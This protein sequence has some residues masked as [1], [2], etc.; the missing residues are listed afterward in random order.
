[1]VDEKPH[2]YEP[3]D[4]LPIPTY[5]EATSSRPSSAQ[6]NTGS[7]G[8]SNDAERQ[9]LLRQSPH[10]GGS[11][12]DTRFGGYEPPTVESARTSLEFL[13]ASS[14]RSS[15]A[16]EEGL[17][18]EITQLTLED[19]A[20]A[21]GRSHL[22]HSLSKRITSFTNRLSSIQLTIRLPF[23]RWA[24]S[25]A[26]LRDRIPRPSLRAK[27][28]WVV[29]GRIFGGFLLMSFVYVLLASNIFTMSQRGTMGQNYDP[30]QVRIFVQSH[31]NGTSIEEYLKR[32]TAYDH[33]AGTEGNYVLARWV[34]RLF[35]VAEIEDVALERFDVY[36]NYPKAGG[37]RVAIVEPPE[38]A[39]EA[40]MEEEVAY[41]DPPRQQSLVFHG[42]SQA[43]NVTGPLVYANYGSR[44]DF[45][46]L[47]D[48][49]IS[50]KGAIALVRYYGTQGDRALKV[51]A[52]ELAGAVG[53]IIYSDPAEDGFAKGE[54]WPNGRFMPA[55]GVQRGTVGLTSWIVGDVL[56]PGFASLPGEHKRIP[57]DDNPGLNNIPSIPLAWRDA[58]RLLQ[59][60]KGHGEKAPNEW[61]GAVP[62]VDW[63]T[64]DQTSPVVQLMNEQD[65]VEKQPIYNVIGKISGLE[66]GDGCCETRFATSANI[67]T[68]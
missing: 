13:S 45:K 54:P 31:V 65:E 30:E 66:V 40:M 37:R 43:G 4:T 64:G 68:T 56:S 5:E 2:K 48:S 20:S 19:P 44:E 41:V 9:G 62:D 46:R 61:V 38:I 22:G 7:E 6:S 52:A 3:A 53:C 49:G 51:K 15:R 14:G 58:Q 59:A 28:S 35:K 17:R 18:R 33:V 63:W 36:L 39:W 27:G 32:L 11:R 57:K 24:A 10:D 16:S 42:Y 25:F 23:G 26:F 21:E 55:D 50:V 67:S 12:P 47:K 34:E 29:I 1:M 60:L 8:I